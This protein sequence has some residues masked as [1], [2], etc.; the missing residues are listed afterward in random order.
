MLISRFPL[1]DLFLFAFF[2]SWLPMV[3]IFAGLWKWVR[4]FQ[5]LEERGRTTTVGYH[6]PDKG[7]RSLIL[8]SLASLLQ[9]HSLMSSVSPPFLLGNL[10][11][12]LLCDWHYAKP[13]LRDPTRLRQPSRNLDPILPCG[14]L[15]PKIRKSSF[16]SW[17]LWLSHILW[18]PSKDAETLPL[19]LGSIPFSKSI[20]SDVWISPTPWYV[21]NSNT[22]HCYVFDIRDFF[23]Y[24]S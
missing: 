1:W 18:V 6:M 8:P 24:C 15:I 11:D 3:E 14:T 19:V 5:N 21:Y 23:L 22:G 12:I 7:K 2:K 20:H 4:P 10:R 13:W 17:G 9:N 16:F